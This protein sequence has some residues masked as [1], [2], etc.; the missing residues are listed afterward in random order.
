[1][2]DSPWLLEFLELI[3][4][5]PGMYLGDNCVERLEAYILG[6]RQARRDFGLSEF[7]ESEESILEGFTYWLAVKL[8]STMSLNWS[9][10]VSHEIDPSQDNIYTFY[11]HFDQFMIERKQK[12]LNQMKFEY[13]VLFN[14]IT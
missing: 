8:N 1:M 10:F 12:T 5:K 3:R 9:G 2:K 7:H 6:Y 4:E 14:R 11:K 13:D